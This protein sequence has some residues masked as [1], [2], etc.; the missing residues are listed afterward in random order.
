[1]P[2]SRTFTVERV[3]PD[4]AVVILAEFVA[5]GDHLATISEAPDH[6]HVVIGGPSPVEPEFDPPPKKVARK[7]A[8]KKA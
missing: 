8:A 4:G 5:P 6:V 2:S 3:L 7:P 1:M